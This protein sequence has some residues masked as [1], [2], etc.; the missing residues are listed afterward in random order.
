M[1]GIRTDEGELRF[2]REQ[3]DVTSGLPRPD[4]RWTYTDHHGHEHHWR[5]GW[6][7]LRWVVDE[8]EYID[9]DGEEYPAEGH[10]ECPFCGEDISPGMRGPSGFRE[11]IPGR[12]QWW[13][14]GEPISAERGREIYE[15]LRHGQT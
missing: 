15:R 6:P 13:L 14:N 7:T 10:Y 5:D 11:F 1:A 4:E 9:E 8:P 3:I 2:E 12:E